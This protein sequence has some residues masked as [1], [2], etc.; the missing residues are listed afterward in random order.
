[1]I[2]YYLKQKQNL[3]R[4]QKTDAEMSQ[5][6][7]LVAKIYNQASRVVVW[8]RQTADDSDLAFREICVA[9][10]KKSANSLNSEKI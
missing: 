6:R 9:A 10:G 7:T 5:L 8:L 4:C 1:M 3:I 2:S